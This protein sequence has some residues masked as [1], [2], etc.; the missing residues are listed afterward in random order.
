MLIHTEFIHSCAHPAKHLNACITFW[1]A[2]EERRK[3]K[4]KFLCSVR[5]IYIFI[6]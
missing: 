3:H 2:K 4:N 6:S 5:E 1:L